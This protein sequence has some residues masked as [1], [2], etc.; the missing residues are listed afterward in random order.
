MKYIVTV[1]EL[2]YL[3]GGNADCMIPKVT[4]KAELQD[5]SLAQ[6]LVK[7][8]KQENIDARLHEVMDDEDVL[9]LEF[10]DKI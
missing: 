7:H 1:E 10:Y 5:R 9:R 3:T 6:K 4:I 8:Y 2:L